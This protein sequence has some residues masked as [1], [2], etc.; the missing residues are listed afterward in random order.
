[1]LR[2]EGEGVVKF[3]GPKEF[4]VYKEPENF[5]SIARGEVPDEFAEMCMGSSVIEKTGSQVER[6]I[7]NIKAKAKA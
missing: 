6:A 5:I 3:C 7:R 4:S 2:D 1:M